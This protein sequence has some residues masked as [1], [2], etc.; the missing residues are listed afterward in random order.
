MRPVLTHGDHDEPGD[1][2]WMLVDEGAVATGGPPGGNVSDTGA[3]HRRHWLFI[4]GSADFVI[5]TQLHGGAAFAELVGQKLMQTIEAGRRPVL[6][7]PAAFVHAVSARLAGCDDIDIRSYCSYEQFAPLLSQAEYAFYWNV[8]SFSIAQ[9]LL[10]AQPFFVFDR[11]HLVRQ[12]DSRFYDRL[13]QWFYQ[14]REP[15][16]ID[17]RVALTADGLAAIAGDY[18]ASA[19]IIRNGLRRSPTADKLIE[20]L[21]EDFG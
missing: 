5:Q 8:A 9:R 16:Y 4:L 20:S 21:I 3:P 7:A 14:G 18:R 1:E 6:L 15:L 19:L 10:N 11:G 12:V 2:L 17:Q 13:I